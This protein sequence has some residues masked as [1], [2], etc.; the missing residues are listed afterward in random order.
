M[1]FEHIRF[2]VDDGVA[3]LTLNRPEARNALSLEMRREIDSVLPVL[4]AQAGESIRALILTGAGANFCAGG[5]VKAMHGRREDTS[6]FAGRDRLRE[7]HNRLTDLLNLEM[8]V[9]VAVDGAAAGA[10]FNLALVGD[11]VLASER[12]FF[13]QSFVRIGL[14]PDWNG[15][16]LLPRLIGLSKA[17]ELMLTGRRVS[18]QEALSLGFVHSVHAPER[19][20]PEARR[21]ARRFLNAPTRAIGLSKMMLNQSFHLDARALLELEAFAQS[22]AR[23]SP[24]HREAV[25]RFVRKEAALFDWDRS[26]DSSPAQAAVPPSDGA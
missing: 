12:A 5:D 16:H 21:M 7:A 4:K 1:S 9:I 3:T 23:S 19:L 10:G 14:V 24:Y 11:F 15:F 2:E 25:A 22:T 17:R 20:M 18:A 6:A 13:V 26:D 8:P